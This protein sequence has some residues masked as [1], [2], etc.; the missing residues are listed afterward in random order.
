MWVEDHID[1]HYNVGVGFSNL[2][3]VGKLYKLTKR[4]LSI[5]SC[6]GSFHCLNCCDE[7]SSIALVCS[8][9]CHKE[10]RYSCGE[11]VLGHVL[12]T[13]AAAELCV[14]PL[15]WNHKLK[16]PVPVVKLSEIFHEVAVTYLG[17]TSGR[18]GVPTLRVFTVHEHSKDLLQDLFLTVH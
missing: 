8:R 10:L 3:I 5:L 11:L 15:L 4:N 9:A 12:C 7:N 18:E 13:L 16:S 17:G 6:A 2:P 14:E 1:F